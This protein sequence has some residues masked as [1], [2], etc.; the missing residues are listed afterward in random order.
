MSNQL[1]NTEFETA[2]S[3]LLVAPKQVS[4]T[5][6]ELAYHNLPRQRTESMPFF[7]ADYFHVI[8]NYLCEEQMITPVAGQWRLTAAGSKARDLGGLEA[9]QA[10]KREKEKGGEREI[11]SARSWD[12]VKQ[13]K[14]LVGAAIVVVAGFLIYWMNA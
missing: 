1:S 14:Y 5:F 8:E 11:W 2:N 4:F 13:Y 10:Y 7:S 3:L 6:H 9:Y 12:I